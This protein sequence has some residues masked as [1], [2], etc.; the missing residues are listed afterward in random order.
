MDCFPCELY[1]SIT[2]F[3]LVSSIFLIDGADTA[4]SIPSQFFHVSYILLWSLFFLLFPEIGLAISI[5]SLSNLL[6]D[7]C[8]EHIFSLFIRSWLTTFRE[9]PIPFLSR[10]LSVCHI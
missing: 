10:F 4:R 1:V 8:D 9:A 7:R 6:Y 5:P 3:Q 2:S